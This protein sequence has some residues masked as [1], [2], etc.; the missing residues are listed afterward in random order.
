MFH[1]TIKVLLV[2]LGLDKYYRIIKQKGL[3]NDSCFIQRP[4][5]Y[6]EKWGHIISCPS[7]MYSA[8]NVTVKT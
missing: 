2:N 3:S 5:D 1:D 4:N 8:R 6:H 7:A